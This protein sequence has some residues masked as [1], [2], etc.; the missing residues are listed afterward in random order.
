MLLNGLVS[1]RDVQCIVQCSVFATARMDG[2][3]CIVRADRRASTTAS[4]MLKW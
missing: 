1:T 3:I 2:F 4:Y